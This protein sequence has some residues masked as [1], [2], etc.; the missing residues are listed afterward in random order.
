MQADDVRIKK[1]FDMNEAEAKEL[2]M[3]IVHC[4]QV[5]HEQ[6]LNVPWKPPTDK[7]FEFVLDGHAAAAGVSGADSSYKGADS[8]TQGKSQ[9]KQNTSIM[10]S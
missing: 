4:D 9:M 1:V 6:Q 10:D 5:I 8:E 3:K 2:V 7:A